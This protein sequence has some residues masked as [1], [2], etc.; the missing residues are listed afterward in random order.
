MLNIL[1]G[2]LQ[3]NIILPLCKN[4]SLVIFDFYFDDITSPDFV[5]RMEKD[6]RF[7]DEVQQEDIMI[8]EKVQKGLES[9]GYDKGRFSPQE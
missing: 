3:T 5:N 9:K 8:C 6:I 4:Q 1:P 2:R 7:S